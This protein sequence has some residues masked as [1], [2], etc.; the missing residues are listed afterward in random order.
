MKKLFG[1][2]Q[3]NALEVFY[4]L[5]FLFFLLF[6]T[7]FANSQPEEKN[8]ILVEESFSESFEKK[9]FVDY[10]TLEKLWFLRKIGGIKNPETWDFVFNNLDKP[11]YFRMVASYV[12]FFGLGPFRS[13][14]RIVIKVFRDEDS[15]RAFDSH[16]NQSRPP[17]FG[18]GEIAM[19]EIA[20]NK[21]EKN[22]S[23]AKFYVQESS[24]RI[25]DLSNQRIFLGEEL[26]KE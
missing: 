9:K 8:S 25:K 12:S 4:F 16:K 24:N 15:F 5:I 1:F 19:I 10:D 22:F 14:D 2:L 23:L 20:Y 6:I 21:N 11:A 18:N 13:V 26:W 7:S 17:Y 3:S